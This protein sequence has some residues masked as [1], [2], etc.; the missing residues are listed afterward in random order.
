MALNPHIPIE[1]LKYVIHKVDLVL[2]RTV[3]PGFGGQKFNKSR[4]QKVAELAT[5]R[6]ELNL[7][8]LIEIDGGVS[9]ENAR[10]LERA[11]ADVLVAGTA[12]F[13]AP[14]VSEK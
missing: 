12:I 8:F 2:V 7:N 9:P 11:G 1:V 6:K 3:N 14:N 4:I 5:W 10:D 13:N